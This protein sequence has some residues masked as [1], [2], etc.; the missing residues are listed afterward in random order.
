MAQICEQGSGSTRAL[1]VPGL[2]CSKMLYSAKALPRLF[3]VGVKTRKSVWSSSPSVVLV[4]WLDP[5]ILL[6]DPD[7]TRYSPYES[8]LLGGSI[9]KKLLLAK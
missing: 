9:M 4:I 1:G 6:H 8:V 5:T 3:E 7:E 2:S